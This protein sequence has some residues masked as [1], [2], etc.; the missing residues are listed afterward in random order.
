[1]NVEG[2]TNEFRDDGTGPCP[3]NNGV[4]TLRYNLKST[5]GP[6]FKERL[7]KFLHVK[8]GFVF[9]AGLLLVISGAVD[10]T[11]SIFD[12][13]RWKRLTVFD[14]GELNHPWPGHQWD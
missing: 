1:M 14:V 5:K 12:G 4:F 13:V 8:F 11:V 6:F 3:G 7:I 9:C 2:E 10:H